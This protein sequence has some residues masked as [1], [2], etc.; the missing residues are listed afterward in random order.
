MTAFRAATVL[1]LQPSA[2][3][4]VETRVKH[5][6]GRSQRRCGNDQGQRDDASQALEALHKFAILRDARPT[7]KQTVA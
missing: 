1:R 4:G 5:Q 7:V 3:E 6:T 2:R